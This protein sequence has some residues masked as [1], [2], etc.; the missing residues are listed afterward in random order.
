MGYGQD[1]FDSKK[2][3]TSSK[4]EQSAYTSND[5]NDSYEQDF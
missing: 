3:V 5:D 1:N 2:S 4:M